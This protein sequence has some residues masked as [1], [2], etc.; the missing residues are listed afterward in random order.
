MW[1]RILI[2]LTLFLGS[3]I[4][5]IGQP[6]SNTPEIRKYYLELDTLN[7]DKLLRKYHAIGTAGDIRLTAYRNFL[8]IL[9]YQSKVRYDRYMN[10]SD[11]WIRGVG[12]AR[13]SEPEAAVIQAEIHVYRAVLASQFSEYRSAASDLLAAYR[14]VTRW[15]SRFPTADRDKLSGF[16]GVIFRQVP[17]RHARYLTLLGVRPSGLSGFNGLERYFSSASAGSVE[18][19][20]GFLLLVTAF[21]EFGQDPAAAWKFVQSGQVPEP[22]NPLVRYQSA[23]A[24]L[25]AGACGEAIQLLDVPGKPGLLPFP[26]WAY[27]LGR[28]KLYRNDPNAIDYLRTFSG[29]AESDNYRHVTVLMMSWYYQLTDQEEKAKTVLQEM[30]RLPEPVT[31]ND[32][33]ARTEAAEGLPD[34][35]LL[36]ARLLYDGGYYEPCISWCQEIQ[37]S[38]RSVPR[39]EGEVLY[40]QARAEQ[41]LGRTTAAIRSYLGVI[42]RKDAIRSY[43]VPNAALQLGHLYKQ[44]GQTE[45]ARKYYTLCVETNTYG[46]REGLSRQAHAALE[47]LDR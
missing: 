21:K 12:K 43:L 6:G 29:H 39:M 24:A 20:E 8:L 2:V 16:L 32:R 15:G 37:G 38:M 27:Q 9:I 5:V 46:Y 40:R 31:P 26:V 3:G 47:E 14:L 42:D 41:R 22:A 18:R 44:S 7:G 33:Q 4:R 23:L 13:I 25:K 34:P 36:R 45:L 11:Q 35:R 30:A 17:E 1:F 28:C 10:L 19:I